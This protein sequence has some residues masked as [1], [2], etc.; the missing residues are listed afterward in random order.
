MQ[1]ERLKKLA[2]NL[3]GYSTNVQKGDKVLIEVF[4]CAD[5]IAEALV[6]AV[7]EAGGIPFVDMVRA[8]VQRAWLMGATKEQIEA[9]TRWDIARM[10]EMDAYI[11]FRGNDNSSENADVPRGAMQLYQSIYSKQVHSELRVAKTKWVV[12][13]YPNPSMAQ[14]AGMSTKAFEDYYFKVCNLDYAKMDKAMDHLK[15]LM[16][17]TDQVRLVAPDTDITFS[18][19]GIGSKKCAGHMNVPDGEVYSAPGLDSV[20][21]RIT[22]NTPSYYQGFKFE[23][24]SL[25]F[26]DGVIVEAMANDMERINKILD[27]DEGARRVGEFSLGVNPYID[28][29]M[30]DILF[31][32]KITGSIHFTPGSA[33]DDADNGNRSAVH[34]DLVLIQRKDWGGGEIYF[35]ERLIR[36]DG[37]FVVPEL[38]CLNPENLV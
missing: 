13:R 19:K 15:K 33:Y 11:A 24:V 7:Y 31:D 35:D 8:R 32:E 20:N 37:I 9:Q 34:W 14:L 6:E 36:K 5:D 12:L 38:L 27:T 1:D 30:C 17:K 22:Y 28:S 3:V 29:P 16:D 25:T 26:R 21:G 10:K 4:D 23:N 18:I 2:R